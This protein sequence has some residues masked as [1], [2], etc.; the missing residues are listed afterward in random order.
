MAEVST[1]TSGLHGASDAFSRIT[2]AQWA[3]YKQRFMPYEQKLIGM[4]N[5]KDALASMESE[6]ADG[7]NSA[8][9]SVAKGM[10]LQRERYGAGLD[11]ATAAAE[12]RRL[13]VQRAAGLADITNNVRMHVR[14]RDEAMLLGGIGQLRDV[15]G[16]G[17]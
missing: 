15:K 2:R 1:S 17:Q 10:A 5:N 11:A 6:G 12:Q 4:Y 16:S 8:F 7:V 3:D 13:S 14:D 9:D